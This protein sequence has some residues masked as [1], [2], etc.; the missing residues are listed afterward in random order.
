MGRMIGE[1]MQGER[2]KDAVCSLECRGQATGFIT[3]EKHQMELH[4]NVVDVNDA[5]SFK[6]SKAGC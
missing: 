6:H 1:R 5:A 4:R 2:M 3:V